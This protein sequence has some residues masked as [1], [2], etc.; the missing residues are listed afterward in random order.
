MTENKPKK[1]EFETPSLRYTERWRCSD[2]FIHIPGACK[3]FSKSVTEVTTGI[4][5]RR[6]SECVLLLTAAG[7]QM[8]HVLAD[9]FDCECH[10]DCSITAIK[11]SDNMHRIASPWLMLTI[12][13]SLHD[14]R[15]KQRPFEK[16]NESQPI[17][18]K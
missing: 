16:A 18:D 14:E 4:L 2:P 10:D 9:T 12:L 8:G 3:N 1:T 7:H 6:A 11:R 13:S 5:K 17:L 15:C